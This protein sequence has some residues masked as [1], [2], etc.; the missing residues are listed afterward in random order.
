MLSGAAG[1]TYGANGIW[2]V[3]TRE[4]SYGPS[5]H[6][7]SWGDT[8]WEE[9]FRLPGSGQLGLGKR[10]LERYEWWRFEPHPEWVEPH[11]NHEEYFHPYAA[12]IPKEVRMF[13]TGSG[14]M[15]VKKLE[16]NVSYRAFWFDPA[17]GKELPIG[18]IRG[19]KKGQWR[20]P[21]LPILQFWVLVLEKVK[22]K[23]GRR[24]LKVKH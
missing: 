14:Y 2:Q 7:S 12:G 17:T 1:H 18:V 16:R 23:K 19:D 3:N 11:W 15:L 21:V 5:P 8:P 10:L 6:G 9:A 22:G 20:A 4:K 13:F 24:P